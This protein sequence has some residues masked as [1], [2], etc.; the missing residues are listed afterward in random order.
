M[1][2]LGFLFFFLISASPKEGV[3]NTILNDFQGHESSRSVD[4]F[5]HSVEHYFT[6]TREYSSVTNSSSLRKLAD[7]FLSPTL[8][9]VIIAEKTNFLKWKISKQ[10][11]ESKIDLF[12]LI[13]VLR[14]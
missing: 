6:L 13:R 5:T 14:I 10:P 4:E 12:I 7:I 2:H 1:L 8:K 11:F 9:G 3:E